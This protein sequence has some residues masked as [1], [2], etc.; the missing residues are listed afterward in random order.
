MKILITCPRA[1]VAIEWAQIAQKSGH[2]VVFVD[3]LKNPLG[4]YL[5]NSSY[6]R[7]PSPRFEFVKYK[8]EILKLI[9]E[10]D[11]T[12]P[13][14]EDVF[15]LSKSLQGTNLID[16]VFAPNFALLMGLH[17]KYL[18]QN[19]LNDSVKFPKTKLIT[20]IDQVEYNNQ[21]SILKPVFSRF[22]TNVVR[23]ISTATISHLDI[24]EEYPWI[25]QE[26]IEGKYICNYAIIKNGVV[27]EH[28]VYIPRYLVNNAAAT[29]F[30]YTHNTQCNE[31]IKKFA[32][33]NHFTG[34]VAF[35]FIENESGL[36]VIECNPR[37]TSG[38]HLISNRISL[39]VDGLK[40]DSIE[41][42]TACRVGR[43]ILFMFGLRS[44]A[45]GRF[46]NLIKDYRRSR[47]VLRN[48][49]LLAQL[50][51]FAELLKVKRKEQITFA[52]ATAYDIEYN[53]EQ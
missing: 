25:Q 5:S 4:K 16:R 49:P 21:R 24:T 18:V 45:N 6:I 11:L 40:S 12:I 47:D 15:Y 51:S 36:Y 37:A 29:Y 14:C 13:T 3:T 22:G 7:I 50:T 42:Y 53:N 44:L 19:Y 41:A 17:N 9:P 23:Q 38:L 32:A 8:E 27:I 34:Q 28:V 2:E 31:F 26:K 20:N 33:D 30:E 48:I 43:S 39:S 10:Y 1:P 52:E 46:S 35:D